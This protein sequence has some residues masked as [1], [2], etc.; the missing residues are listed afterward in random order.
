MGPSDINSLSEGTKQTDKIEGMMAGFRSALNLIISA[1]TMP[2][3]GW[4]L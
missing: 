2:F 3:I 4:W 1:E